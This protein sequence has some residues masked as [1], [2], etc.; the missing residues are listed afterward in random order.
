MIYFVKKKIDRP[1]SLVKKNDRSIVCMFPSRKTY[2]EYLKAE[3][4]YG[5]YVLKNF[6]KKERLILFLTWICGMGK[7]QIRRRTGISIRQIIKIRLKA[8]E[9]TR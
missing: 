8:R 9:H 3:K 2:I 7:K 1:V 6:R 5:E 4:N